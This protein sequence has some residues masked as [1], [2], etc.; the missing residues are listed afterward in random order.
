MVETQP[1][2][3][4]QAFLS[5]LSADH[6]RQILYLFNESAALV[7]SNIYNHRFEEYNLHIALGTSL[8]LINQ[9]Q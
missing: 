3:S 1:E 5:I 9:I 2:G 7:K 4:Q 8:F 6:Y